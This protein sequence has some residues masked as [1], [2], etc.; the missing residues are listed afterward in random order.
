MENT[1]KKYNYIKTILLQDDNRVWKF[2]FYFCNGF[3][4]F[5]TNSR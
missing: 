2:D 1:K 5:L 4:L 3:F